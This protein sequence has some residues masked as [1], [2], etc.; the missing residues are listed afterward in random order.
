MEHLKASERDIIGNRALEQANG[1]YIFGE[2]VEPSYP[3]YYANGVQLGW[4]GVYYHLLW[5]VLYKDPILTKGGSK[6]NQIVV[7]PDN[8]ILAS[9][10]VIPLACEQ[11]AKIAGTMSLFLPKS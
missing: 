9:L 3:L 5:K 4:K 1:I 6:K 11:E 2:D 8:I 10:I 7:S